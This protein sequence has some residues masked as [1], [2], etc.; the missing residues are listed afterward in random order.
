MTSLS[1]LRLKESTSTFLQ[2]KFGVTPEADCRRSDGYTR[3]SQY[4][5]PVYLFT[6]KGRAWC[7]R[8]KGGAH[9]KDAPLN[10]VDSQ[11]NTCEDYADNS[12][13]GT[14]SYL[15]GTGGK[16]ATDAC[17]TCGGRFGYAVSFGVESSITG[18]KG[19]GGND[20]PLNWVDSQGNTCKDYADNSYASNHGCHADFHTG[21]KTSKGQPWREYKTGT[22]F[23]FSQERNY[24]SGKEPISFD[25]LAKPYFRVDF[26][27][28]MDFG[29]DK[30][31]SFLG[32]ELEG[33]AARSF[34]QIQPEITL[35]FN[36]KHSSEGSR[37]QLSSP[38]WLEEHPSHQ[39]IE[40]LSPGGGEHFGTW[41]SDGIQTSIPVR[42]AIHDLDTA[43]V[44]G[45]Q[46]VIATLQNDDVFTNGTHLE[47][48]EWKG[49]LSTCTKL[50]PCGFDWD[51]P[52]D[53]R[54][55]QCFSSACNGQYETF[56]HCDK[57]KI[58]LFWERDFEVDD[59]SET[60]S[61]MAHSPFTGL[62][63]SPTD[64]EC[65]DISSPLSITWDRSHKAF[66]QFNETSLA[67]KEVDTVQLQIVALNCPSSH[68]D[69]A[70]P[71]FV[72]RLTKCESTGVTD[73][74]VPNSGAYTVDNLEEILYGME[75]VLDE[76]DLE[77][78]VRI[79]AATEAELSST[80]EG[81]FKLSRDCEGSRRLGKATFNKRLLNAHPTF[82]KSAKE[83][84]KK[85]A[86]EEL[87]VPS[88]QE[89]TRKFKRTGAHAKLSVIDK[90]ITTAKLNEITEERSRK[91]SSC[92]QG[93]VAYT[94]TMKDSYG[95]GWNGNK[96]SLTNKE[97]NVKLYS[98]LTI[99]NGREAT[100]SL[101]I[102]DGCF[103]AQASGGSYAN[104]I[105]WKITKASGASLVESQQ[106]SSKD[107]CLTNFAAASSSVA[108]AS[109]TPSFDFSY[110]GGQ[111]VTAT[112]GADSLTVGPFEVP[113]YGEVFEQL[114]LWGSK[115]QT[116]V[117]SLKNG[118]LQLDLFNLEKFSFTS[119]LEE[120]HSA[121]YSSKKL[122]K[123]MARK[124]QAVKMAERARKLDG[125]GE[126]VPDYSSEYDGHGERDEVS[127]FPSE[128]DFVV[129]L[130]NN[131]TCASLVPQDGTDPGCDNW[132]PLAECLEGPNCDQ[133]VTDHLHMRADCCADPTSH[134]MCLFLGDVSALST[135]LSICMTNN[136][137]NCMSTM[138]GECDDF[139]SF[140]SCST[141]TDCSDE[142]VQY[143]NLAGSCACDPSFDPVCEVINNMN[144][145]EG[146]S[147]GESSDYDYSDYH[148]EV[149]Y[150]DSSD[151]SVD[152]SDYHSEDFHYS[153]W[154]SENFSDYSDYV[155][156]VDY[157]DYSD[158]YS[159]DYYSHYNA[160]CGCEDGTNFCNYDY[161][162]S[163]FCEPCSGRAVPS[164]CNTDG[165]PAAG[166]EDCKIR[167]F[168][169]DY[170]SHEDDGECGYKV[171]LMD[172]Y[173]DGRNSAVFSISGV[174]SDLTF[175][176]G[177]QYF[178]CI[179]EPDDQCYHVMATGGDYPSEVSWKI[180]DPS[181]DVVLSADADVTEEIC[182]GD[183]AP[184]DS[185]EDDCG[186]KTLLFDSFGDGWN[187]AALSITSTSG[188]EVLSG[189]TFN[190]GY[191]HDECI[192]E[193]SEG[194]YN[195]L[196][197]DG[198]YPEEVSWE[199]H[200]PE[201]NVLTYE[202]AGRVAQICFG[203]NKEV[204][205]EES[206]ENSSDENDG[207][208]IAN[209][210]DAL[211]VTFQLYDSYGDGWNG[212]YLIILD[213]ETNAAVHSGQAVENGESQ[214]TVTLY[215][216]PGCYLV[217]TFAAPTTNSC[218]RTDCG[219][220]CVAYLFIDRFGDGICDDGVNGGPN[221]NCAD[222]GYDDGDCHSDDGACVLL[223]CNDNCADGFSNWLGDGFCDSGNWG[224]NFNCEAYEF[225]KGDCSLDDGNDDYELY[226]EDCLVYDC[227]GLCADEAMAMGW[228]G[229]GACDDGS[230]GV[231]FNCAAF[232]F[233]G[234]D[235]TDEQ[236]LEQPSCTSS[237]EPDVLLS[238]VE[239]CSTATLEADN[240]T[241]TCEESD[242]ADIE[243]FVMSTFFCNED[244][245]T[246]TID[247]GNQDFDLEWEAAGTCVDDC[248]LTAYEACNPAFLTLSC[249]SNCDDQ[250]VTEITEYISGG[251]IF[252]EYIGDGWCDADHFHNNAA[253]NFD[254]GDC[255]LETCVDS[256][257]ECGVA[258][259]HCIDPEQSDLPNCLV[260]FPGYVNDGYCDHD[261]L[262]NTKACNYDGG[263]CCASSCAGDLCG[264][265][266]F[267]CKDEDYVELE[268]EAVE[269]N[270]VLDCDGADAL[271]FT[272]WIGDGSCDDGAYCV[273]FNCEEHKFDG[274]DCTVSNVCE[275]DWDTCDLFTST[276]CFTLFAAGGAFEQKCEKTCGICDSETKL[277]LSCDVSNTNSIGDGFCD[278]AG[279]FNTEECGYD[280][281]DCC[282]KSCTPGD[283][284]CGSNGYECK[285]P[286]IA[287]EEE[288]NSGGFN[289]VGHA[290]SV[291]NPNS[292][293]TV[294]P[295]SLCD[296]FTVTGIDSQSWLNRIYLL[297]S[298]S[299]SWGWTSQDGEFFYNQY[300]GAELK[301]VGDQWKII[302]TK[303]DGTVMTWAST[304]A[305]ESSPPASAIWSI[306]LKTGG[307][308]DETVS[309]VC[310]GEFE[311]VTN[312]YPN[313]FVEN[314]SW[315]GDGHCDHC[316]Y[317]TEEC[318][319]DGGDCCSE[320]CEDSTNYACEGNN[321]HC[322]DPST[323][324]YQEETAIILNCED[325]FIGNGNCDQKN[326]NEQ[327]GFDGGDCCEV[328]CVNSTIFICGNLGDWADSCKDPNPTAPPEDDGE[329]S[330]VD[331][332]PTN[333]DDD[334]EED[335]EG[336]M[337]MLIGGATGGIVLIVLVMVMFIIR[338]KKSRAKE[339][340]TMNAVLSTEKGFSFDDAGIK[341]GQEDFDIN[342][343]LSTKQVSHMI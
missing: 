216:L 215:F 162:S 89:T 15:T 188:E 227:V 335:K 113:I 55:S 69:E 50:H 66:W 151:Y 76:N 301:K 27:L 68:C 191:Q 71:R 158:D 163:G 18:L 258:G 240:C 229:D 88:K 122:R 176:D 131:P 287:E 307:F 332:E 285:D 280:G 127:P 57:F 206:S 255:C 308:R 237:C 52:F 91:L 185:G 283:Y 75:H 92:S 43:L 269:Q 260:Q 143:M 201:G 39:R 77:F 268:E 225:D 338:Q 60:F 252:A 312:D 14:K 82:E 25:L 327:C 336:S 234:D 195:I 222:A 116:G 169:S 300:N 231:Y 28:S 343:Q 200:D 293:D 246:P 273:N 79:A 126:G 331:G 121:Q 284:V 302:N 64:N 19:G 220:E 184:S 149:H 235:C 85:T 278:K 342:R 208:D 341:G 318:G 337:I 210:P 1:T 266:G 212:A 291:N 320:T 294:T 243:S 224:T 241:S 202:S 146:G 130:E 51:V 93:K 207:D 104:E 326:N 186:Y 87:R 120:A 29:L 38:G 282:E 3:S 140:A 165:L 245:S 86:V 209:N 106:T 196:A 164:D 306:S 112:I 217:K 182:F 5:N 117:G 213:S 95:D 119:R 13:C 73:C 132:Q 142:V 125:E 33:I 214:L 159:S 84:S 244:L 74:S 297:A 205:D 150:S 156:Y 17:S 333:I 115:C 107:F 80:N 124:F 147:E 329:D 20:A 144:D 180:L 219:G 261:G 317:N 72:K 270:T 8:R 170:D 325:Y 172:G 10:W 281:G 83:T 194:C 236:N 101:C 223:D 272:L 78:V 100:Q 108:P 129:C 263:D 187:R 232:E 154:D 58:E 311:Q 328:S 70:H 248:D 177:R 198:S 110:E 199:I 21:F 160:G 65:Y 339:E 299:S 11:G 340:A 309:I 53:E 168:G 45:S 96:F 141:L 2:W 41:E 316:E 114:I 233:D 118:C 49:D 230:Y 171:V 330:L 136:W 155:D 295:I 7:D 111:K 286:S 99:A 189:L 324:E 47:I 139:A 167:C 23:S 56:E 90:K 310:D 166:A 257:F 16:K 153:D 6:K 181:G 289:S 319:F 31:A 40:I 334:E 133:F 247:E 148:S 197:S 35:R 179:G 62:I 313:C 63:D 305:S 135:E 22:P 265:V 105:S 175:T 256:T 34:V 98:D 178:Q 259:F 24:K 36:E 303:K 173:G 42:F 103:E 322:M 161:G 271:G 218:S 138:V 254:G 12:W 274:G 145:N 228:V 109:D 249:L 315:V 81:T 253:Q 46:K 152:Y 203:E 226:D 267:D 67:K 32:G 323:K 250:Y 192:G 204:I 48:W 97:N 296:A 59:T 190:S 321:F 183:A 264:V 276:E 298:D 288:E 251:C 262:Y 137:N 238:A 211:A 102:P 44:T 242:M 123:K 239:Q 30:A 277:E 292:G 61:L 26:E 94:L 128:E 279:K 193:P 134:N 4:F 54:I 221:L 157:S 314:R 174:I 9:K 304:A 275:D 290:H 37:R